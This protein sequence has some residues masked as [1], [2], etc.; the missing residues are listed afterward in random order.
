MWK[1]LLYLSE[2]QFWNLPNVKRTFSWVAPQFTVLEKYT[3][4]D[5]CYIFAWIM[6]KLFIEWIV[7]TNL[8]SNVHQFHH[9]ILEIYFFVHSTLKPLTLV[10]AVHISGPFTS[11]DSELKISSKWVAIYVYIYSSLRTLFQPPC[12]YELICFGN[13][14]TLQFSHLNIVMIM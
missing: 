14:L 5:R 12:L 10:Y 13:S 9:H 6:K 3:H 7:S 4:V 11:P 8:I 1:T 2:N